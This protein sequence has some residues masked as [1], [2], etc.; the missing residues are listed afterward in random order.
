MKVASKILKIGA[1]GAIALCLT[2]NFVLGQGGR[3]KVDF[4]GLGR[5]YYFNNKLEVPDSGDTVTAPRNNYGTTLVDLGVNVFPNE[6]TEIL[7]VFRISNELGGYWGG[8]V[9]FGVRQLTLKGVAADRF[10]Y[11][12]GDIDLKLTDYT[13]FNNFEDGD[14]NEA[15]VF[16]IQRDV[17]DYEQFYIDN[18]W[19]MQGAQLEFGVKGNDLITDVNF[20]GFLTRQ[21]A[22]DFNTNPEQ[23][24]GGGSIQFVNQNI[25]FLQYNNTSIFDVTQ[26]TGDSARYGNYVHSVS[27]GL[28]KDKKDKRFGLKGE[29]GFSKTSYFGFVDPNRPADFD[30]GF[31]EVNGYFD[32]KEKNL[33]ISAG[34]MDV[35]PDFR[36][37][38]AQSK[39]M[40]YSKTGELYSVITNEAILR[41]VSAFDYL[42]LASTNNRNISRELPEYLVWFNNSMPFGKATPNR[43]GFYLE[44]TK[45]DSA[46]TG[47][48]GLQAYMLNEIRGEGTMQKR[49]FLLLQFTGNLFVNKLIGWKR[50]VK[51]TSGLR[52][53]NT[54]RGG[55]SYETI[56]MSNLLVDL[57]AN[58]EFQDDLDLLLGYKLI[59]GVGNEFID[60]RDQ[61]NTLRNIAP[62]T[63]S[64]GD[65]I[66]SIG[67]RYRF[68]DKVHLSAVYQK[69]AHANLNSDLLFGI[70]QF[71]ILYN[72]EF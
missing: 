38:G 49:N 57:G 61:F 18:Y 36:S 72:M 50:D 67:A 39:R 58:V 17:V 14:V 32:L 42:S 70:N 4:R 55:Q 27:W 56:D 59:S 64:V 16:D 62:T 33:S 53:E 60:D 10:R 8:G 52:M 15:D 23:L 68:T 2:P 46:K 34:F 71:Y 26:T 45:T 5:A 41:P 63:F 51:L 54:T 6:N 43:R 13:L 48:V 37:P 20:N 21:R 22:S 65:G 30:D 35:G 9:E 29:S 3:K 11:K 25:G 19:R 66:A 31:M 12:V 40:D 1:F 47:D 69:Y 28:E 44:A 7:G 24:L